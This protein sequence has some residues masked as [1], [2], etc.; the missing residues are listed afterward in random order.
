M[1]FMKKKVLIGIGFIAAVFLLTSILS[2]GKKDS[3][4][5]QANKQNPKVAAKKA[6]EER[7][8][9]EEYRQKYSLKETNPTLNDFMIQSKSG[10]IVNAETGEVVYE[11]E[12]HSQLSPASITKILTCA[13]ALE[14]IDLN[15][16]LTVSKHSS[17]MEP[18]NMSA[19]EGEKL[20]TE[21]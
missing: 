19:H 4:A 21:D 8:K 14:N 12:A 2:F 10:I 11:K 16:T 1:V 6:A 17:E 13:V 9:I 18:Y 7:E 3:P 20:K 15:K 5:S